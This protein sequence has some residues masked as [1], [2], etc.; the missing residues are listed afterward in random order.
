M[1]NS[2][3]EER[4]SDLERRLDDLNY[5]AQFVIACGVMLAVGLLWGW[6]LWGVNY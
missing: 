6:V 3:N 4:I 5:V 1:S 2:S